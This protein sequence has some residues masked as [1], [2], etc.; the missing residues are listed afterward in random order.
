MNVTINANI[1]YQVI[2]RRLRD[3]NAINQWQD[4]ADACGMANQEWF[5]E[6][7]VPSKRTIAY[8]IQRM[9]SGALGYSAPILYDKKLGYYYSNRTFSIFN[10]PLNNALLQE[11]REA[12]IL[13]KQITQNEKLFSLR[14]SITILEEKL[15]LKIDHEQKPIIHIEHSLNEPG[16]KWLDNVYNS[17]RKQIALNIDYHPFDNP[18]LRHIL[19]PY[20]MKEYNNRWYVIGYE[21]QMCKCINLALDRCNEIH[22]SLQPY[23]VEHFMDHDQYY[24]NVYGVTVVDGNTLET[25]TFKA[26]P[27]LSKYLI[28]KPIHPTQSTGL[29]DDTGTIF[30]LEVVINYEI[31]HKLLSYGAD[32]E[33]LSP[34][35]LRN[36]IKIIANKMQDM[37]LA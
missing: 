15:N 36:Q 8:D 14:Q 16:Q 11:L 2:D 37:Y 10:V 12:I 5:G 23:N 32:I 34:D 27:L 25:T 13:L 28:T 31:R 21:H 9:R 7:I 19:S 6:H 3:P 35:S 1:R 29:S 22:A 30:K 4:L 24:K 18:P 33:I 26:I 20:F 17:I